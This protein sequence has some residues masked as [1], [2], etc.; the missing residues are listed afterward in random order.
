MNGELKSQLQALILQ[1]HG[2]RKGI[3]INEVSWDTGDNVS[4]QIVFFLFKDLAITTK[5]MKL[6]L[7]KYKSVYGDEESWL[8]TLHPN[9][10][11]PSLFVLI[12]KYPYANT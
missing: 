9:I 11:L 1:R 12:M 5:C 8:G 7:D 4:R 3:Y 2:C 6:Y 10:Y